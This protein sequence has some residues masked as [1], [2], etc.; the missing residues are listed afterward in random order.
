M[1]HLCEVTLCVI[2]FLSINNQKNAHLPSSE[3]N[4]GK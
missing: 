2:T 3:Q 1:L 4:Q